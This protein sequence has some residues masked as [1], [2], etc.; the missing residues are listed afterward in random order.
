[1]RDC[2]APERRSD[3]T[4]HSSDLESIA[5]GPR[6]APRQ[7]CRATREERQF[8]I[9]NTAYRMFGSGM[10]HRCLLVALPLAA[11]GSIC[12]L[13]A[14]RDSTI[15]KTDNAS[16]RARDL[17]ARIHVQGAKTGRSRFF[18]P[19]KFQPAP[20][21]GMSACGR[22]EARCWNLQKAARAAN[23]RKGGLAIA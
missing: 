14:A 6:D 20:R 11:Q 19:G 23:E 10:R 12:T 18:A 5:R 1:M 22:P 8:S 21:A 3:A 16:T 13:S 4:P 17:Q 2:S 7:A 15:I 9:V